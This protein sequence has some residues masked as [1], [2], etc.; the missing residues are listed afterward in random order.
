MAHKV[1]LQGS[2]LPKF[3][4]NFGSISGRQKSMKLDRRKFFIA[5]A[6]ASAFPMVSTRSAF[7]QTKSTD[8]TDEA[9]EEV[10]AKPVLNLQGVKDP[11]IIESIQLLKKGR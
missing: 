3:T 8:V 7:G 10:A 5:A 6:S 1:A 9:L 4:S 11:I 2:R